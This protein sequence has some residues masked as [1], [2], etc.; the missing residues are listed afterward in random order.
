MTFHEY[1]LKEKK[2]KYDIKKRELY[3][4]FP[5]YH[6]G[7]SLHERTFSKNLEKLSHQEKICKGE[8]FLDDILG[9][10]YCKLGSYSSKKINCPYYCKKKDIN[11]LYACTYYKKPNFPNVDIEEK[12]NTEDNL[13]DEIL[14]NNEKVII[15][16]NNIVYF[17]N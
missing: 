11:G 13:Y 3:K 16:G 5:E 1:V 9:N 12:S 14:N 17:N 10:H 2:V 6:N 4:K 15:I 8:I 7:L